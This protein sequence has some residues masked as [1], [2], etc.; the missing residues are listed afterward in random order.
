M[1]MCANKQQGIGFVGIILIIAGLL[2]VAILAMKLVPSYL[3]NMQI[4]RIFKVIVTD[5]EMQ[6]ATVKDI[7]ASYTKRA[8]MDN[9]TEVA[10]EDVEVAKDGGHISLSANYTVK[11][12]VA[13]NLSLM[14]DFA[15]RA[16]N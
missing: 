4:E 2:F 3:H 11:I 5:P 16:S 9:I 13:G 6:N 7:R 14:A 15:P 8:M 1:N 12:P 10:A